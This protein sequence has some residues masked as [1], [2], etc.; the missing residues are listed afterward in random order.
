MQSIA[1][2]ILLIVNAMW[3]GAGFY[4]FSLRS[5]GAAK[6]LVARDNR[7]GALFSTLGFSIRFLGGLNFAFMSLCLLL[8]VFANLF[9]DPE[10]VALFGAVL[11]VAN[12]SQFGVNVPMI[13]RHRKQTPGAWPVLAGPMLFI[14]FMDG[15]LMVADGSFALWMV[16]LGHR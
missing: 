13:G 2:T 1:W 6:L 12:A 8:L 3:F 4:Q 14:F 5:N 11:A 15:A 10:Q 7:T 9:P 16:V